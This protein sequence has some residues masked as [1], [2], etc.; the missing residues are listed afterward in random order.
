ME[1]LI[2]SKITSQSNSNRID[3]VLA[4]PID[5]LIDW[6]EGI[7][8]KIGPNVIGDKVVF[9]VEDSNIQGPVGPV[10]PAGPAG[11]DGRSIRVLLSTL[12]IN[13]NT[14]VILTDEVS[15]WNVLIQKGAAGTDGKSISVFDSSFDANGNTI[16]T[17]TDG[18]NNWNVLIQK[19]SVGINGKSISVFDSSFDANGNTIVTLTDGVNNWEILIQK[20][21]DGSGSGSGGT[22]TP[23]TIT[24]PDGSVIVSQS[25]F[26]ANLKVNPAILP[27]NTDT[28]TNITSPNGTINVTGSGFN[29]GLD[30]VESK[31]KEIIL[32]NIKAGENVNIDRSVTGEIKIN[33]SDTN[34]DTP[35]TIT[36]SDGSVLVEQNGF[37]ANLKVDNPLQGMLSDGYWQKIVY[38]GSGIDGA[39]LNLTTW[40]S[41]RHGAI[42]PINSMLLIR[43]DILLEV[44]NIQ[45]LNVLLYNMWYNDDNPGSTSTLISNPDYILYTMLQTNRMGFNPMDMGTM[46]SISS[47]GG[48]SSSGLYRNTN[49][50][51]VSFVEHI[52]NMRTSSMPTLGFGM[53]WQS[54]VDADEVMTWRIRAY[55]PS[56]GN[57]IHRF[58]TMKWEIY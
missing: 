51:T 58:T 30:V 17:L 24:S 1:N 7:N 11:T 14:V 52:T 57:I 44:Q 53:G 47:G 31:I 9:E 39:N 5:K 21:A 18:I 37:S 54:G 29:R 3:N 22:D 50:L 2:L 56:G 26:Y 41:K 43:W 27:V 46:W 6:T 10:G 45:D 48:F 20:G 25:G 40:Q 49:L 15:V 36:S 16:I 35:T 23:T 34:T 19:G 4:N 38:N 32:P 55:N 8:I 12:D 42:V 28:A 13:G 33:S